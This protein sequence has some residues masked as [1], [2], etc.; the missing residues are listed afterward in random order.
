MISSTLMAETIQELE[1]EINQFV[2]QLNSKFDLDVVTKKV[3]RCGF[4]AHQNEED[5]KE[6][7]IRFC[8]KDLKYFSDL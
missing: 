5:K 4:S 6:L 3:S 8:E 1:L 2:S 7:E